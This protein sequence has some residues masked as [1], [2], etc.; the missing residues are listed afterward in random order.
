MT[1]PYKGIGVSPIGA[2]P[3]GYGSPATIENKTGLPLQTSQGQGGARKINPRTKDYV[4]GANGRLEGQDAIEAR[5]YLAIATVRNSSSVL[6]FGQDFTSVQLA[7]Q[8]VNAKLNDLVSQALNDLIADSSITLNGV[9]VQIVENNSGSRQ[10]LINISWKNN[11][12]STTY[13][14][15]I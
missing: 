3:F 4:M 10:A 13:V 9:D 1:T 8:N 6:D 12:T 14:T 15:T 2:A 7:T 11:R 5:V